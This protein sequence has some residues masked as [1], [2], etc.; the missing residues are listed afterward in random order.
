MKDQ[1]IKAILQIKIRIKVVIK[2]L[3]MHIKHIL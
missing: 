2:I 3:I 1:I